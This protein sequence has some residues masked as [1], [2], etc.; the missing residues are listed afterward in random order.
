MWFWSILGTAFAS[1]LVP[2]INIEAVLAVTVSQRPQLVAVVVSAATVGQMAGK[3][4]WYWGGQ[5]AERAPWVSRYLAKE[6]NQRRLERWHTR[7]EGRPW[8]T[9]GVLF[10]SA[11]IGFPPYAV[12][13]VLAGVLRVPLLVFLLTGL[14]GRWLR[15]WLIVTGTSEL[16]HLW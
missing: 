2:L 3:Y 7:T 1:A 12:A 14:A 11:F 9:A 4:L 13:S 16:L 8:L 5:R 15:F 6:K 10:V